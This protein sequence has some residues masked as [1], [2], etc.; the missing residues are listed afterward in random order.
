MPIKLG[1]CGF[2]IGA[3]SYYEKFRVVEVHQ[4]FYDPPSAMTLERWRMQAPPGFEFTMKA[5]QVITHFASSNT[6]RR[7]K[8]P[9]GQK[10]RDEAG[11][12]RVNETTL[13]A[14]QTTLG[15]ARILRATAVLF[16]CPASF[17]PTD[18]NVAAMQGWFG[19]IERPAGVRLLWEPRGAW[20][21][22]V[23][24]SLCRDLDLVHTVDPFIRPSLTPELTYWRLHG[25]KSHYA[26]YTDEELRQIH[27]WIHPGV[28]TYVMFNN[29]P[30]VK[31]VKRFRAMGLRTEAKAQG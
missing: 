9:F 15:C 12:F 14:W 29:I 3:A 6:Y 20:P 31:D 22:E 5:W 26:S 7:L 21:D 2:T 24:L 11:G 10:Q 16:Q 23:V 17:R 28:E 18:D 1:M 27:A 19:E 25:N 8:R 30:R 4:T 13:A